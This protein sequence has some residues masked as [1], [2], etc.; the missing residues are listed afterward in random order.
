[1]STLGK[2]K[3]FVTGKSLPHT[4][5]PDIYQRLGLNYGV[6]EFPT[7]EDFIAW[8]QAKDYDGFNVTIPYKETVIPALDYISPEA[9]EIGAVNTVVNKYGKLFGYNTD[10]YGMAR[11]MEE[12]GIDVC[13]KVVAVL[14]SG[15]T[16]KCAVYVAKG[17]GAKTVKVC[18]RSGDYNYEKLYEDKSVE[19]IINTTPVG[20]FPR[21]DATVID[22]D[23]LENVTAVYDVI[24]N[25]LTT[26]LVQ[27]AKDKG[28]KC[29]NGL[30]MLI[31][32]GVKAYELYTDTKLAENVTQRL[33][34][35][36]YKE[37]KNVV[38]VGMPGSGKTTV[39]TL[40]A[41]ALCREFFDSDVEF[42]RVFGSTPKEVIL[43]K[44]ET[45]FRDGE[46][47]II[48]NLCSKLGVV[49]A[50]GGGAILKEE[51]RLR[52]KANSTVIFIDRDL[53]LLS[54]EGRPLSQSE[55]VKTLYE[56][57]LPIYKEVADV[58]VESG[59]DTTPE[60]TVQSILDI[61]N[62]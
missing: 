3:Y 49:V 44:G 9:Q 36:I 42:E 53:D 7:K 28:L 33:Y 21:V 50:T 8:V 10:C 18:S 37:K 23:K 27:K 5:S 57:R 59:K 32:Q 26:L 17:L 6:K 47:E 46:S 61:L 34:N 35:D 48:A 14:G 12:N 41:K 40:I 39:G 51:N 58:T 55:G 24:Y 60:E 15:G 38:L 54:T 52:L 16:S 1:M 31:Y 62:G 25:P 22:L 4:L 45:A 19:V 29:G 13:G 11:A 56:K 20:M 2:G 43:E 30:S